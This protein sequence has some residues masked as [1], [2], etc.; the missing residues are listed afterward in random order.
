VRVT[1]NAPCESRMVPVICP[2]GWA[3][4][5]AR[6]GRSAKE[7]AARRTSLATI[8]MWTKAAAPL[9]ESIL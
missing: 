6:I 1:I 2:V 9:A 4:P 8:L 3:C 5:K 7:K